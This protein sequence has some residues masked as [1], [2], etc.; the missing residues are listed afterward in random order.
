MWK[1]NRQITARW[2]FFAIGALI[3]LLLV[4]YLFRL[5]PE[6][7][8]KPELKQFFTRLSVN[9]EF[10][11]L[12]LI[13]VYFII[14][15]S[16]LLL[17]CPT[18]MIFPPLYLILGFTMSFTIVVATQLCASIIAIYYS[19]KKSL[20]RDIPP[21]IMVSLAG[22]SATDFSFWTRLYINFP[23]RTIDMIA[24][25]LLKSDERNTRLLVPTLLATIL[26]NFL[27]SIWFASFIHLTTG[28][29]VDQAQATSNFLIWS[30]LLVAYV[31]LPKVPELLICKSS[32]KPI[33]ND[34]ENWD[35]S[36]AA[37]GERRPRKKI[38]LGMQSRPSLQ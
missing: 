30:S 10:L 35:S 19:R 38:K 23:Q 14:V 18:F 21:G 24:A 37:T 16:L 12:Y 4:A 25:G 9:A 34:I 3:S 20:F 27:P 8:G 2:V 5:H 1:Y 15:T 13:P 17:G 22:T 6:N 7:L 11:P 26:R 31:A 36:Q 28:I 29:S 33:L 32:I